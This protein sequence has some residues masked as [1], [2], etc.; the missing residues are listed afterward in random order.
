MT[1]DEVAG[2]MRMARALNDA[3]AEANRYERLYRDL[4]MTLEALDVQPYKGLLE[5][6][7]AK[8]GEL[9]PPR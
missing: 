6:H 1:N 8:M 2:C 9:P 5:H 3:Q 7:D 4:R